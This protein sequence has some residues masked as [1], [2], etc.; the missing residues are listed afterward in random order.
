LG[1]RVPKLV[2][3]VERLTVAI[4]RR[5]ARAILI[6][7]LGQLVLIKRTKLGQAP[8]WTAPGGGVDDTDAS[9]EAALHRELAEELGAT[10]IWGL[11]VPSLV[12]AV[13]PGEAYE[14]LSR[15]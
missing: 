2:G 9:V 11:S 3:V 6:D 14:A 5:A 1:G 10:V 7:D 12:N 15:G 4:G 13:L 8:Y